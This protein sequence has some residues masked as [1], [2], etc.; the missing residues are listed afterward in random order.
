MPLWILVGIAF[1]IGKQYILNE[2]YDLIWSISDCPYVAL[3]N[4]IIIKE[5]DG[6][7][8]ILK[9][10]RKRV[11]QKITALLLFGIVW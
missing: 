3:V 7:A 1:F 11:Y 10:Y 2:T 6:N 4:F 9:I 5:S 8:M